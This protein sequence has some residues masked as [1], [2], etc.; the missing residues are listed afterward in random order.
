MDNNEKIYE[1]ALQELFEKA[2]EL[3]LEPN[4]FAKGDLEDRCYW[5]MALSVDK[6]LYLKGDHPIHAHF[7]NDKSSNITIS[8]LKENELGVVLDEYEEALKNSRR[9]SLPPYEQSWVRI[10]AFSRGG[11]HVNE[12]W[13]IKDARKAIINHRAPYSLEVRFGNS[14]DAMDFVDQQITPK[15]RELPSYLRVI[16]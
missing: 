13:G 8:G 3:G 12:I 5:P 1:E 14:L 16:K 10:T 4:T 2:R 7:S 15:E 6:K 11:E 9:S